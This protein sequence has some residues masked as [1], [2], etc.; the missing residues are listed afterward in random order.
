MT[1]PRPDQARLRD[2]LV[3]GA[4]ARRDSSLEGTR[5]EVTRLAFD[6]GVRRVVLVEGVSDRVALETLARCQRR[7]LGAE[8]ILIVPMGGATSIGRFLDL[9]DPEGG[10]AIGGMCDAAEAIHL[11]RRLVAAGRAPS[12]DDGMLAA[13]GFHVCDADLEDELLRALGDD[14]V[15]QVLADEGDLAAFRT[16]QRQPFQRERPLDRQL[17]RFLASIGGRKE[18][19]A[20]ALVERLGPDAAPAPLRAALAH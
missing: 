19:Y 15:E 10:P 7:D 20:A 11:L 12:D 5:A 2:L 1:Q 8:G 18:R 3:A 9:L 6:A 4:A 13:A 16:F 14:G 17:R